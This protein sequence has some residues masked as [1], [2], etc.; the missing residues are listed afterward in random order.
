MLN[1]GDDLVYVE[2]GRGLKKGGEEGRREGRGGM[3]GK[4]ESRGE[5]GGGKEERKRKGREGW[6]WWFR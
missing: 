1:D 6:E 3:K 5:G 4:G 2:G